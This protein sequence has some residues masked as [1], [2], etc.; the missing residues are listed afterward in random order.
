MHQTR[1]TGTL[2]PRPETR[3]RDA[4]GTTRITRSTETENASMSR[5]EIETLT[6]Q[7]VSNAEEGIRYLEH[8]LL[9]VPGAPLSA[10]TLSGALFQ[11]S[12]L[13][14]IRGSKANSNAVRAIAFT[15]AGIESQDRSQL[16]TSAVVE[17]LEE[18][19]E[20]TRQETLAATKEQEKK[21]AEITLAA[22][23]K[24]E[25]YTKTMMEGLKAVAQGIN[26]N[27]ATITETS[28]KY[29]DALL[30]SNPASNPTNSNTAPKLNH[31]APLPP[32]VQAREGVRAR[33]IL[34]DIAPDPTTGSIA[35]AEDSI[36]TLKEKLDK[37]LM[38][39]DPGVCDSR[40]KAVT[41][42]RNGGILMELD[43]DEAVDWFAHQRIRD[44]FL[45]KLH[46]S[47]SI[48]PRTFQIVVQFIPLTFRPD[49]DTD[50]RELEEVNGLEKG[51]ILQARWI[52]PASRRSPSQTCGHAILSLTS[53]Q[54][55]NEILS[56]GLFICHKK[57]YAE[58]CKKE[59]LRCLK[60]HGWS[61]LARDCLAAH[62]TCGTCSQ[63]HRTSNCT[64]TQRPHCVP[65]GIAGH[66]SWD[67]NCPIFQRKCSELNDRVDENNMPYFPT[68]EIWTQVREPPKT[69]YVSTAPPPPRSAQNDRHRA[70]NTQSTLPWTNNGPPRA[71]GANTTR[72]RRDG[73]RTWIG[74]GEQ[75]DLNPPYFPPNE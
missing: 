47:A 57:V 30:Q 6:G 74:S 14:G 16:L 13:P 63:R 23:E 42:L 2:R 9:T 11:V 64:N 41:R 36:S 18:H 53:P 35:L 66:A 59:P 43:S 75:D 68:V 37:A 70:H 5:K 38:A 3:D 1:I 15:L 20:L 29:R 67:R 28:T 24:I 72:S 7:E 58:K 40:T 27:A 46:P 12:M 55:A 31:L 54:A 33:Q 61:H 50:I 45:G 48:K 21:L 19:L 49:R 51:D 69:I 32:R 60:C 73:G 56:H 39:S 65:C 25:V 26:E 52:K 8:T 44:N 17:K 4:P 62:D 22:T 71:S 10:D 34:I